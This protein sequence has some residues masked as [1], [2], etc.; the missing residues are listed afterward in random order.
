MIPAPSRPLSLV[1]RAPGTAFAVSGSMPP[2]TAAGACRRTDQPDADDSRLL[3]WVSTGDAEALSALYDR[4]AGCML[5]LLRRML[6]HGGD[7][8]E[9]LQET[10]LQVWHQAGRYRVRRA[11][12]RTWLL[13]LA[14]SRAL[15]RMRADS[16][17][18]Q[19]E[20]ALACEWPTLAPPRGIARLVRHERRRGLGAALAGLSA[21]QR[22]AVELAF[23]HG[24]TQSQIAERLGV[25]L[26]T[27]KSRVLYGLKGLRR[28][29]HGRRAAEVGLR[30][31]ASG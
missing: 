1:P 19:R 7:A 11:S 15:D 26:G 4:H 25:P 30:L 27:V 12:G 2:A 20:E 16:A 3:E 18:R 17:R 28:Q 29:L 31:A 13:M 23:F 8:E 21:P 9:V 10:F 22:Q 14:R 24:L 5:G 6:G